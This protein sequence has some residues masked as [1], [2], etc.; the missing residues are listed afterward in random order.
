MAEAALGVTQDAPFSQEDILE[1]VEAVNVINAQVIPK[2]FE[3]IFFG[4][5]VS[6][7]HVYSYLNFG[8][9]QVY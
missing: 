1:I 7:L 3:T 4:E 8:M 2:V 5:Y 9:P 6:L